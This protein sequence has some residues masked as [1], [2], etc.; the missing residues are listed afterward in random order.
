MRTLSS[1]TEIVAL[2]SYLNKRVTSPEAYTLNKTN[3][4]FHQKV[5]DARLDV[6]CYISDPCVKYN[7][8]TLLI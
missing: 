2:N 6:L 7:T 4:K 5:G 8:H 3:C 1:L